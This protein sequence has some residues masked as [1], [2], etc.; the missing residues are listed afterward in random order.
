[1][2]ELILFVG[3]IVV[4]PAILIFLGIKL[5]KTI[6]NRLNQK[7]ILF[8][9][10]IFIGGGIL[11]VFVL[12]FCIIK[13]PI[14]TSTI[15]KF[16]VGKY[17]SPP[18]PDP[19]VRI[20]SYPT[21]LPVEVH[22]ITQQEIATITHSLEDMYQKGKI[23]EEVYRSHKRY[24]EE[25]L[26]NISFFQNPFKAL[27]ESRE[28]KKID[29]EERRLWPRDTKNPNLMR[30]LNKWLIKLEEKKLINKTDF[31]AVIKH[32]ERLFSAEQIELPEPY[33]SF[34]QS[35]FST[36]IRL[37]TLIR[38]ADKDKN[39]YVYAKLDKIVFDYDEI[40]YGY[41]PFKLAEKEVQIKNLIKEL[42]AKQTSA[43]GTSEGKRDFEDEI[44]RKIN[45]ILDEGQLERV[46]IK[47]LVIQ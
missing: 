34:L 27:K 23:K 21:A 37:N 22:M 43:I 8:I 16:M 19:S 14:D 36:T 20:V 30:K 6:R 24:I 11:I 7:N 33:T 5:P 35:I 41:L 45:E 42:L 15:L 10:T 46:Y 9:R 28:W 1:M 2:I 17:P 18:H 13:Y 4:V 47:D 31:L 3:M 25:E 39:T 44:K 26:A 29:H 12:S 40:K 38:L 32:F